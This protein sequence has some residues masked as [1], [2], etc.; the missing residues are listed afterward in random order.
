MRVDILTPAKAAVI[1]DSSSGL[2]TEVVL[3]SL[4]VRLKSPNA[5]WRLL[6]LP[7]GL[8]STIA[9]LAVFKFALI[10]AVSTCLEPKDPLSIQHFNTKPS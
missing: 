7:D 6:F 8:E 4:P 10:V 3:Q 1:L 2:A 9:L 5:L